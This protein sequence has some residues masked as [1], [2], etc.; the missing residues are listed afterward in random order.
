MVSMS[1]DD[2]ERICMVHGN[3][4]KG[5]EVVQRRDARHA[6]DTQEARKRRMSYL[7]LDY[8]TLDGADAWKNGKSRQFV[9]KPTQ[10]K[11]TDGTTTGVDG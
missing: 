1:Q 11:L 4:G 9:A 6:F 7:D 5:S 8:K 10:T 3:G 2:S